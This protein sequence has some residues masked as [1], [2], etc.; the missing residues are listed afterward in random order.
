MKSHQRDLLSANVLGLVFVLFV[1]APIK[2]EVEDVVARCFAVCPGGELI[3]T[4]DR[5]SVEVRGAEAE[6]ADIRVVRRVPA[7]DAEAKKILTNHI[8][9][10]SQEG[11]KVE[12]R[13]QYQGEM[14]T[15]RFGSRPGVQVKCLITV[16]RKF[17]ADINTAGDCICVTGLTGRV[18]ARTFG[19]SLQFEKID[20]TLSG[21]T[22]GGSVTVAEC[23]GAV[24][25]NTSGGSIR[26]GGI[27]GD[28]VARTSGGPIR[29]DKL[30]G[31]SAL[32]TSGGSIR[33]AA[34]K[35]QIQATTSGGSI[36]AELLDRPTGDCSFKTSGG[37]ITVLLADDIAADIDARTSGGRVW[38]DLFISPIGQ[39]CAK[40]NELRGK[41]NGGGPL[42]TARTSG[43][44]VILRKK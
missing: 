38:S 13:A 20:G 7:G 32:E 1:A 9:R 21:H 6:T 39:R 37:S 22:C 44:N 30:N 2:A 5:G 29:A 24:T 33:A 43:G 12:V 26:L 8:V 27:E 19:G 31:N 40:K 34:I 17:D 18:T 36:T 4:L 28:V 35:G 10:I 11:T 25:V 14:R 41:I 42:V 3:V 16:P 23:K 15:E